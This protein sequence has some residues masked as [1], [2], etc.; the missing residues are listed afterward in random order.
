VRLFCKF[1]YLVSLTPW[2]QMPA[3]PIGEQ[4]VTAKDHDRQGA[5][6]MAARQK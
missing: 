6:R 3:H 2:Q 1:Q 5:L 4:A